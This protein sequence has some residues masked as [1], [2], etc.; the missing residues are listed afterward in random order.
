VNGRETQEGDRVIIPK[1]GISNRALAKTRNEEFDR[2]VNQVVLGK[3]RV[4]PDAA[5]DI[6]R[7]IE[8]EHG[9][10]DYQERRSAA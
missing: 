7:R 3:V 5:R 1:E 10:W 2:L 8:E 4:G 9:F 6:A